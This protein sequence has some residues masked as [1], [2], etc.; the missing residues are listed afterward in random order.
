MKCSGSGE[1]QKQKAEIT[2]GRVRTVNGGPAPAEMHGVGGGLEGIPALVAL[3]DV[4]VDRGE[5]LR[6]DELGQHPL[7]LQGGDGGRKRGGG[8][9]QVKPGR[10]WGQICKCDLTKQL[11][12]S[13]TGGLQIQRREF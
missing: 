4:G 6:G 5:G 12:F 1:S 3:L 7:D 11:L 8:E 10:G 2:G 13:P 9:G